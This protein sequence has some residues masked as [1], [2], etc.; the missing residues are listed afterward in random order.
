MSAEIE[1]EISS[2]PNYSHSPG[3]MLFKIGTLEEKYKLMY[4]FN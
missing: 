1:K 2:Q 3:S 4:F